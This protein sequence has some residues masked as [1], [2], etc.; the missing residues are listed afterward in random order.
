MKSISQ[1]AA[2]VYDYMHVASTTDEV[3]IQQRVSEKKFSRRASRRNL[4]IIT[5]VY[6]ALLAYLIF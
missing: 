1:P 5:I 6:F 4:L 3:R 2:Y